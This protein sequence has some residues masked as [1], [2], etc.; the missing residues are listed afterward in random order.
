MK[1][2]IAVLGVGTAG[3]TSLSHLLA[4][5]GENWEVTCIYDPDT[6][7]LGIGE[8]TTTAIPKTLYAGTDFNVLEDY[9]Y[10]DATIKNGVKYVGWREQDFF[11]KLLPPCHGI[12]FNNFK[13]KDFAFSRFRIKW[14]DKFRTITGNITDLENHEN[15]AALVIENKLYKFDW[16]VDCRGYPTDYDGYVISDIIPVNHCLVHMIPESGSWPWTYHKAHRNGWMFGIPLTTRQGWGYLYN[17]KITEKADAIDDICQRFDLKKENCNFR[18]FAFKNYYAKKFLEGRILKNGNRALFYEPIEAMSGFFYDQVM[19]HFY[20]L[21]QGSL[22]EKT[23]NVELTR[24]AEDLETFIAYIYHGGSTYKSDFWSITSEKC[25]EKIKN[26][27]RFNLYVSLLQQ[28]TP[29]QRSEQRLYG[30][31]S[32]P[33]WFDFDR[34]L[35][36]HL[37]TA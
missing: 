16:I 21:L 32:S 19:R 10:L 37:L 1:N 35:G 24:I 34:N 27:T 28:L 33:N 4:F 2:K 15:H 8:S 20:D 17:D 11:S 9:T 29:S 3:I 25:A 26:D 30:I 31:F 22:G 14:G 7:I 5:L 36:Y 13:L 6:P 12:H 18:E 23:F